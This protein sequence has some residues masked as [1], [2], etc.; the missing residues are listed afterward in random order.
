MFP[1][2]LV[3]QIKKKTYFAFKKFILR[4]SSRIWDNE[5]KY[6]MAGK[7]KDE[8]LIGRMRFARRL[9]KATYTHLEHVIFIAFLGQE[10]LSQRTSM[11]SY[12]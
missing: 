9:T 6:C 3:E 11:L 1:T 12:S 4:K 5:G 8:I 10:W 7:A 2:K